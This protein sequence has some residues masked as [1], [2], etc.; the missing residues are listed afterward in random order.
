MECLDYN[1]ENFIE[2]LLTMDHDTPEGIL[3]F[4]FDHLYACHTDNV[5]VPSDN[6]LHNIQNEQAQNEIMQLTNKLSNAQKEICRLKDLNLI[7]LDLIQQQSDELIQKDK[8]INSFIQEIDKVFLKIS[9]RRLF[10]L[11]I[12]Q[13]QLKASNSQNENAINFRLQNINPP[14]LIHLAPVQVTSTVTIL[15][16]SSSHV[17]ITNLASLMSPTSSIANIIGKKKETTE[18]YTCYSAVSNKG[19]VVL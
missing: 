1:F 9:F 12:L 15:P 17:Q 14:P 8:E 7:H 13:F 3:S 19:N 2:R 10:I 4:P 5:D 11:S 16:E 18:T 6:I